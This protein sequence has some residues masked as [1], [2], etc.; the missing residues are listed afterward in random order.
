M[1]VRVASRLI[2][3]VS[4]C[5]P[6]GVGKSTLV[7]KLRKEFPEDFG[8]SVSHTTRKPRPGEVEGVR[9]ALLHF[10]P[11]A[12]VLGGCIPIRV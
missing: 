1:V 4:V 7:E 11:V 6:S 3:R 10:S 2:C 12:R 5:G 8:F 9:A